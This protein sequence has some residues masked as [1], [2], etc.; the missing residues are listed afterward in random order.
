[1]IIAIFDVG[2]N[3]VKW[4]NHRSLLLPQC[5]KSFPFLDRRNSGMFGTK[6]YRRGTDF[7]LR[8]KKNY[9]LDKPVL[10]VWS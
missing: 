2:E 3:I 6:F 9:D 4:G 7:L 5:F 10:S 8:K 1:M